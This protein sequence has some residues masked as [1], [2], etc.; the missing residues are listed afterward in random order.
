M[1]LEAGVYIAAHNKYNQG[2]FN[3]FDDAD[4]P[5]TSLNK[6]KSFTN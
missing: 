1:S 3:S 5:E 4:G 2:E 6:H